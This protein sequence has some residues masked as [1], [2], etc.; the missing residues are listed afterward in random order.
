VL[1]DDHPLFRQGLRQEVEADPRFRILG[2]AAD[3]ATGLAMIESLAPAVAVIDL[4]LPGMNGLDIAAHVR[5]KELSTRLVVLTMMKDETAFNAAM[6]TGVLGFVLKDGATSEIISCLVA[7]ARGEAYV[8]PSCSAFLLRRRARAEALE[9]GMP[10]VRLLTTAER[11]VL[12]RIAAKRSTK[13][14]AAEFGLSPRTIEA[15]RANICSKLGLK[16]NNSLLQF[17]LE[18]RDSLEDLD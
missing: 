12:K 11:R 5:A 4:N 3:G 2:E 8:S 14:I 10:L 7:V 9:S 13:D 17:A 15:H 18:H 16:G 6:R 1:V